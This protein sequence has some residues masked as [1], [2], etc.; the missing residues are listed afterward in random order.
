MFS[1][2]REIAL[3]ML[4]A[5]IV[6]EM[7]SLVSIELILWEGSQGLPREQSLPSDPEV[8]NGNRKT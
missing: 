3:S 6:H 4:V 2:L 1:D 5:F 7:I 8:Q